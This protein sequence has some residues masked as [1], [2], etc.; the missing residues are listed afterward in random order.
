M[1]YEWI[2]DW[3]EI[4]GGAG[5]AADKAGDAIEFLDYWSKWL[6]TLIGYITDFFAKLTKE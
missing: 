5:G 6:A 3:A 2:A 1:R 4:F